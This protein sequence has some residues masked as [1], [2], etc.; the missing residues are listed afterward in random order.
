MIIGVLVLLPMLIA[1]PIMIY[2]HNRGSHADKPH[3]FCIKCHREKKAREA[4]SEA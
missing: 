2:Q 1:S 3:R 4:G